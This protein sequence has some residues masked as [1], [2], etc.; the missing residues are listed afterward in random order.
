MVCLAVAL[1]G[2]VWILIASTL[3]GPREKEP[4]IG[5]GVF[6]LVLGLLFAFLC[7]VA[8]FASPTRIKSWQRAC[9]VVSPKGLALTQGDLKGELKWQEVRDIKYRKTGSG[10][11]W[12]AT[13]GHEQGPGIQINIE[14]AFVVVADIYNRPLDYILGKMKVFRD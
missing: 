7:F 1:S 8:S 10:F 3:L 13:W 4:W 14:G 12:T 2:G 9:L 6:A 5:V 11:S